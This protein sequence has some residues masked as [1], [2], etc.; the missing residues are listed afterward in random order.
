LKERVAVRLLLLSPQGRLL[1]LRGEGGPVRA[2]SGEDCGAFWFTVGGGREPGEDL[3]T[4]AR[5]EVVEETGLTAVRFGPAVWYSEQV[6]SFHGEPTLFKE[7]FI[8]AHAEAETLDP[9]GWTELEREMIRGWR[10]WSV[11]EI[12]ATAE[13]IFPAG[14]AGLLPDVIAGRYPPAPLVIA[15]LER[16]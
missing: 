13:V 2:M 10:W 1:L 6:L 3:V 7:T 15:P 9:A 14:L 8:V 12:A 16:R 4:T 5:R 11:E